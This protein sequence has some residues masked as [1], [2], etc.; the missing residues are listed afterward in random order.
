MV[1]ENGK[2]G[3]V[4]NIGGHNEKENIEIV[5]TVINYLHEKTGDRQ[6]NENLIK[7]VKDRLG[8][9]RRYGIDPTKIKEELSWEPTV[10][11]NEGIKKTIDW[12]LENKEWMESVISGEYKDFYDKNYVD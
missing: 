9:D 6:I 7:H 3:E 10:M 5:K 2:K 12:Y 8:H 4:Y 11:F 1:Y